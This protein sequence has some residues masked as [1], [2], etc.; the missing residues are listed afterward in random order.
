MRVEL[1]NY[2][3]WSFYRHEGGWRWS[4]RSPDGELLVEARET[5]ASIEACQNDARR[6]GYDTTTVNQ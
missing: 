2:D 6:F 1:T 4:R 3:V 5:F